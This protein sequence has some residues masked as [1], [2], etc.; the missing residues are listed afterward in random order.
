MIINRQTALLEFCSLNLD[1]IEKTTRMYNSFR[2]LQPYIIRK[3]EAGVEFEFIIYHEESKN[4][5]DVWT[6]DWSFIELRKDLSAIKRGDI[7]LDFGSNSGY[8]TTWYGL[9]VGHYGSVHAFDPL[10]WNALMCVAQGKLN[11]LTNIYSYQK[12]VSNLDGQAFIILNSS[13]TTLDNPSLGDNQITVETIDVTKLSH[14]KPTFIKIDIEG[15]E[16]ELSWIDWNKIP[17]LERGF[18]EFHP[19]YLVD[20]GINPL[21]TLER[22]IDGGWD[23]YEV[24]P[25]GRM[26]SRL[27]LKSHKFTNYFIRRRSKSQ[28]NECDSSL[29]EKLD[30]KLWFLGNLFKS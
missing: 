12:S 28:V 2:R 7:V 19:Q 4:W 11:G 27:E 1:E 21:H 16:E 24:G 25:T 6:P 26:L 10:P 17:T 30:K 22:Y 13:R 5:Y 15:Y 14:L 8:T 20:R 9:M 18:L 29:R 23:L 3:M